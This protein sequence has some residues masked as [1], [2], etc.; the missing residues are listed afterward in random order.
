MISFEIIT[1]ARFFGRRLKYTA[2]EFTAD[3][4]ESLY[5]II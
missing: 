1:K 2:E 5:L 4:K 3:T